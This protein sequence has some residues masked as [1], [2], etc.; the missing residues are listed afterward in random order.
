MSENEVQDAEMV[1]TTQEQN[2]EFMT[3]LHIPWHHA[4]KITD[5]EDRAFLVNKCMMVKAMM[6][7]QQEAEQSAHAAEAA[8]QTLHTSL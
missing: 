2:W 3:L 7:K 1:T 8:K 6:Q 5:E 4:M